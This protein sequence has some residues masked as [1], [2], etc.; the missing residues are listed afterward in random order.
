MLEIDYPNMDDRF[1][2]YDLMSGTGSAGSEIFH[3]KRFVAIGK[4]IARF[5][6]V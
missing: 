3:R 1:R 2:K 5:L 4:V 6:F